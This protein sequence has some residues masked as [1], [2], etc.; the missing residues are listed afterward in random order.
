M[1][2]KHVLSLFSLIDTYCNSANCDYCIIKDICECTYDEIGIPYHW[3]KTIEKRIK[4]IEW[5][6]DKK[7]RG[8]GE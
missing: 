7:N 3:V 2:N 6:K 4:R 8:K 5:E 1:D